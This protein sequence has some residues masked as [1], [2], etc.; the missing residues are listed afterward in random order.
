MIGPREGVYRY[1]RLSLLDAFLRLGWMVAADLGPTH[2]RWAILV[3]WPCDCKERV[4][5][6]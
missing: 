6:E 1:A 2:G 5:V 4:P 3:Y